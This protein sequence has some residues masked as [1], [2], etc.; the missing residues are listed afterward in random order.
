[1]MG[2]T[3]LNDREAWRFIFSPSPFSYCFMP[4]GKKLLTKGGFTL[5]YR[6]K[7]QSVEIDYLFEAILQLKNIEECY[8]FFED[9]CT[10]HETQA[11]AQ[12]L[13]VARMLKDKV[14]YHEISEKTGASTATISRVNRCLTYGANGYN[15]ILDRLARK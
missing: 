7:I 6:S 9:L 12:R 4:L 10:I 3:L 8:R 5:E 13:T 2:I 14:T 11:L 15:L 1:M